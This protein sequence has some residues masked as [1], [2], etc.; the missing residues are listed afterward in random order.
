[1]ASGKSTEVYQCFQ[2]SIEGCHYFIFL[3]VLPFHSLL[4]K[5]LMK[6]LGF[7]LPRHIIMFSMSMSDLIQ[8]LFICICYFIVSVSKSG[9]ETTLCHAMR[10][11]ILFIGI[12]T[13][14]LSSLGVIA[15]SIE[16]YIA[17]IHS[18]HIHRIFTHERV[19][20]GSIIQW[21]VA[22][23]LAITEV[24]TNNVTRMT[25]AT[26]A[27]V[28]HIIYIIFTFAAAI[29]VCIIQVRLF[30][31][32]KTKLRRVNPAGAFG[33]QLELADYR[34]KQLKVALVS[35]IV[36]IGYVVCMLPTA[37]LFLYEIFTG[38]A[39]S[40]SARQACF[41]LATA[42][43][44]IDPFI[45]GIGSVDTRKMIFQNLKTVK[46]LVIRKLLPSKVESEVFTLNRI[47]S[48]Q[49]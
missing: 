36:A 20:C 5:V 16:R 24:L 30:F 9:A 47:E 46:R 32:A 37:S 38:T 1:M 42:N 49:F 22:M 10:E 40:T 23:L 4:I 6:D 48:K 45:Y 11:T 7:K 25:T 35:G 14:V 29:P 41:S 19:V 43:C 15:M 34:K 13:T 39:A 8:P 2:S 27:S 21:V 3:L 28:F 17:C 26:I 12:L 33:A 44:L 31:F 18:F